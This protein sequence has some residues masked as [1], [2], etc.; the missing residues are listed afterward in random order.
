MDKNDEDAKY[1]ELKKPLGM[2]MDSCFGNGSI[3]VTWAQS[4]VHVPFNV[5][6]MGNTVL[7]GANFSSEL[8]STFDQNWR[9]S[10]AKSTGLS[11]QYFAASDGY[12][13]FYPGK[14]FHFF[15]D[16][17]EIINFR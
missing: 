9:D 11:W 4:D 1:V 13:R 2:K 12:T 5:Y 14:D 17:R 6:S 10:N 3:P 15:F 16:F 8:D 7:T